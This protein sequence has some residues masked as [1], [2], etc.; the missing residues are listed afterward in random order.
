MVAVNLVLMA[1]MFVHLRNQDK[2]ETSARGLVIWDDDREQ[3]LHVSQPLEPTDLP[4]CK[5]RLATELT[6]LPG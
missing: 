3:W 2:C 1:G 6:I 5:G 4:P